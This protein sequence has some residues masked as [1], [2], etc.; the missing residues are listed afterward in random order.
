LG[1]ENGRS[2]RAIIDPIKG[3]SMDNYDNLPRHELIQAILTL[4]QDLDE[5]M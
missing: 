5:L 3:Y 4:K 1:A 2:R